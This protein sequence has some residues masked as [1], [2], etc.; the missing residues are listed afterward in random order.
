MKKIVILAA[1]ALLAGGSAASPAA[2]PA[3][4]APEVSI[5]FVGFRA[6]RTFDAVSDEVVYIQHQNRQWYRATLHGPC[7]GLRFA[8][9]IGIYSRGAINTLDRFSDLI[10]DGERCK[11]A[12]LVRSGP[13]PKPERKPKQS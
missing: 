9:E 5:P 2:Q 3:R 7:F 13:P 10:V 8:Q 4:A 1:A 11:V 6:I 12:S